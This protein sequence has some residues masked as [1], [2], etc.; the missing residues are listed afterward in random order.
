MK[1]VNKYQKLRK[2]NGNKLEFKNENLFFLPITI[3]KNNLTNVFSQNKDYKKIIAI[4]I[5][6]KPDFYKQ[7]SLLLE[8]RR[9]NLP[10]FVFST[11]QHYGDLL[12]YGIE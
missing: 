6:T 10:V 11:G 5:G 2:D 4:V 12:S 8:A 7:A 1:K 3:N 9:Q